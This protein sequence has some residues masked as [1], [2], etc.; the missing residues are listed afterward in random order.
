MSPA[1][2]RRRFLA[3]VRAQAKRRGR[4]A[5][6]GA[7]RLLGTL[8]ELREEI[9][10]TLGAVPS[11]FDVYR[12]P[13]LLGEVDRQIEAWRLRAVGEVE[14]GI[15][16]AWHLGPEI[17]TASLA[18]AEVEIGATL[19][20][21]SLLD[22]LSGYAAK[23]MEDLG[24]MIK[25]R[26]EATIRSAVLGGENPH[27]AMKAVQASLGKK[28]GPFRFVNFRAETIYRTEVGRVHSMAGHLR[29]LDAAEK[30]PGMGKEWWWSNVSRTTHAAAQGQKRAADDPFS[31]GGEELMYPRDPNASAEN[32][33]NCGCESLPY[34]ADW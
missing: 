24:P 16:A 22:E 3:Q 26:V 20:P 2:R 7:L 6:E 30:I 15:E 11:D 13:Q 28:V 33:I 25:Q 14:R 8:A 9:R 29:L 32:T 10:S 12:M 21:R 19:L 1:E 23:G 27:E 17:V 18:A 31:I 34:K 5:D 4:A